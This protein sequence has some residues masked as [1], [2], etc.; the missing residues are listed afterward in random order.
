[1]AYIEIT[2]KMIQ[3]GRQVANNLS[4][5]DLG[6]EGVRQV[7]RAAFAAAEIKTEPEPAA[8]PTK[9]RLWLRDSEGQDESVTVPF[10][11]DLHYHEGDLRKVT[12]ITVAEFRS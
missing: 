12:Q 10:G 11:T 6:D 5:T 3:A 9:V 7:L 8:R 1:M 4:W 2:D